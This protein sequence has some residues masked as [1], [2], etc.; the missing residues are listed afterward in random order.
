MKQVI[1]ITGATG[2]I[3]SML[4]EGLVDAQRHIVCIGRSENKLVKL[5]E[6]LAHTHRRHAAQYSYQVA[7]MLNQRDVERAISNTV[8]QHGKVDMWINNV[9]VN[10]HDAMGPSWTIEP[11]VWQQ[12]VEANLYSAYLGSVAAINIMKSQPRGY[13]VNFGGGGADQPKTYGSAYGAAKAAV[14]KFTETLQQELCAEQIPLCAF[15]INPGFIKNERT[16]KL[17]NS[18]VATDYMP[19]LKAAMDSGQM[20]DINDTLWLLNSMLSGELDHLSGRYLLADT[21]QQNLKQPIGHDQ[22]CLRVQ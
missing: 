20:S 22:F 19:H 14:V 12:E 16:L 7:D 11:A 9:G 15:C 3:G 1:V 10:H 17:T 5:V 18:T 13:I 8:H 4:A 2:G 6:N 21:I